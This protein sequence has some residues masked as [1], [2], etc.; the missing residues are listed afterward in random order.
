[1]TSKTN[2]II[3]WIATI[4][5][6]GL[7]IFSSI[8][9]LQPTQQGIKFLHDMLGYPIYFIQFISYA[10]LIGCAVVLIPGLNRYVKEWAYAGLF[11][12]LAGAVYS[13][14]ASGG[15]FDPRI[16]GMLMWIIP[17]IVSYYT[18]HKKIRQQ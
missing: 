13:G 14:I 12:D 9:G 2:N 18:W 15:S 11:F 1:M 17:G 3:Y 6:V 4:I 5:F 16:F 7:M 10:K 8:D